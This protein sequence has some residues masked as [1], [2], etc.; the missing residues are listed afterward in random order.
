MHDELKG[1]A[2]VIID[3]VDGRAH[4]V[5]FSD[6]ELTDDAKPGAIVETRAYEDADGLGRLSLAT[7]S[8]LTI[9]AQ[10]RG[11]GATWLGVAMNGTK[12]LWLQIVLVCATALGFV[13]G[14]TQWTAWRLAF[15]PQVGEPWFTFRLADLPA[16]RL[17]LV[18]VRLRR[19]R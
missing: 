14:A 16:S 1:T 19:L 18:V 7:R 6:L 8:D 2:Y 12:I 5:V 3:G 13:W 9:A 4:H 11:L 10:V 15:Q 17:L